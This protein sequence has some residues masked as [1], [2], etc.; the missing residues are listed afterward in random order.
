MTSLSGRYAPFGIAILLMGCAY[1]APISPAALSSLAAAKGA[2]VEVR[3]GEE[4]IVV[5]AEQRP[6]VRLTL[7]RRCS[8]LQLLASSCDRVVTV[9]LERVQV[10]GET[11][12]LEI[13]T[14]SLL[15]R[16]RG[17]RISSAEIERAELLLRGYRPPG[18][19]QRFGLGLAVAGPMGIAGLVGQYLPAPWLAL[20]LGT[21]PAADL[22]SGFAG[23]RLRPL[24]LGPARLFAGGFIAP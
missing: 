22:L 21:L 16:Y 1:R 19:R 3:S 13:P 5:S 17:L 15:P 6:E 14:S 8:A 20:E 9:P 7:N 18:W 11:I 4:A 23:L 2:P 12:S 24:E 10:E